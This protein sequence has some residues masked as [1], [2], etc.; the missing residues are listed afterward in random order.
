MTLSTDLTSDLSDFFDTDEFG[1]S[2]II[3]VGTIY[4]TTI[5]VIFD[6]DY[7][8]V[9]TGQVNISSSQPACMCETSDIVNVIYGH[10]VTIDGNN[11]K[12]RDIQPDGTGI[13]LLILEAQ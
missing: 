10:T 5:S 6:N 12:V 13:T 7:Y 11:Y 3:S 8:E 4:E 9:D 1:I 2:V